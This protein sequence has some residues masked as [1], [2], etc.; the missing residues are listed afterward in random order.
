LAQKRVVFKKQRVFTFPNN[1]VSESK[2]FS[3]NSFYKRRSLGAA[4]GVY[5]QEGFFYG[6]TGFFFQHVTEGNG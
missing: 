6:A 4:S 5:Q 1:T 3:R 2:G